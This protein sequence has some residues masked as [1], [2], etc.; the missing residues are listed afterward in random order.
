MNLSDENK[1]CITESGWIVYELFADSLNT[2]NKLLPTSLL[3][4]C[5]P[6]LVA[7]LSTV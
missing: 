7:K 4:R 3:N 1:Y 5:W 6:I 2:L